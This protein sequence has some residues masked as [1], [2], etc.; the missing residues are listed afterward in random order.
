[1]SWMRDLKENKKKNRFFIK[2]VVFILPIF[3]SLW[4]ISKIIVFMSSIIPSKI[5]DAIIEVFPNS[6][7]LNINFYR[8]VLGF[9][10][11]AL[12]VY[13][14]GIG[15]SILGK[16]FF[17]KIE[18]NIFYNIPVFSTIYKTI[19]QIVESV[20]N[21]DKNSFKKV[22]MVEFPRKDVWTMGFVTGES[23]DKN[24][25]E[26][27]HVIVPTTPNPTSAFLLFILKT[28]VR[29]TDISIDEGIKTIISGGVLTSEY[30]KI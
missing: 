9:L 29:D 6:A 20:S 18:K 7:I 15:I 3:L 4:I 30:N 28:E 26:Y 12:F 11:T 25:L 17:S 13:V 21:P 24:E 1:M 16:K 23:K 5:L 22:V 14:M 8:I 10:M 19:K 2:G 27:Y